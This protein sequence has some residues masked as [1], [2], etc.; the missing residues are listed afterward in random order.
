MW[1]SERHDM[2]KGLKKNDAYNAAEQMKKHYQAE[3]GAII[4]ENGQ[5]YAH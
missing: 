1:K 5:E 4:A 2:C 3:Q